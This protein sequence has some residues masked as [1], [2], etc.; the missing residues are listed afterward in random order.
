MVTGPAP[1]WP[2]L[3][4][5]PGWHPFH[6]LPRVPYSAKGS[7]TLGR[8]LGHCFPHPR[9]PRPTTHIASQAQSLSLSPQL[10]PNSTEFFSSLPQGQ[11]LQHL[12]LI[13]TA[14]LRLPGPRQAP[15]GPGTRRER[16]SP[17]TFV[18]SPWGHGPSP[19]SSNSH[20]TGQLLARQPQR[21]TSLDDCWVLG[22][23]E[24]FGEAGNDWVCC[25]NTG[26]AGRF[27]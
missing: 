14:P 1:P 27:G 11:T 18:P 3:A 23:M 9:A 12:C 13:S 19:S 6:L 4:Q 26:A 25:E 5:A 15:A 2:G 16:Q 7:Q 24:E 8:G 20:R 17:K 21:S 10:S 22:E